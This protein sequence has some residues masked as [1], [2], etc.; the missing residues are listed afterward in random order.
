MWNN[1]NQE[2]SNIVNQARLDSES[3]VHAHFPTMTMIAPLHS[4]SGVFTSI[5]MST[6]ARTTPSLNMTEKYACIYGFTVN[7]QLIE[8]RSG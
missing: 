4:Y 8:T 6:N 7:T 2:Q 5:H 3:G 1:P